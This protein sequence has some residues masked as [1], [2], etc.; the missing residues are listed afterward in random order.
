MD[1]LDVHISLVTSQNVTAPKHYV[2]LT[3][4]LQGLVTSQNVTAPKHRLRK[5]HAKQV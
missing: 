4:V 2:Q 5:R 3:K 1:N